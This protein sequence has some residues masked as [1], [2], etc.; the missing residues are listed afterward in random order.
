MLSNSNKDR[1]VVG[2]SVDSRK[3]V[4]ACGDASS[5]VDLDLA[6]P[7]HSGVDALEEREL[8]R[9]RRGR[10][11]HRVE[12]LDDDVRVADDIAVLVRDLWRTVVRLLRV[13]ERADL[14]AR[15]GDN[16]RERGVGLDGLG[17]A[18]GREDELG[19]GDVLLPGDDAHWNRVA[20]AVLNLL[21]AGNR[22][23]G[24]EEAEV[25]EV[26]RR[27]G[28]WTLAILWHSVS[29]A[30]GTLRDHLGIQRERRLCVSTGRRRLQDR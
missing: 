7:V 23:F 16:D 8:G 11:A 2:S 22:E 10:L 13:R 14:E 20:G 26:V 3:S 5:D 24:V 18:V 19:G 4:E 15:D 21:P 9:V 27:S 29:V 12:L 28:R 30:S 25:D 6:S 1:L 17:V